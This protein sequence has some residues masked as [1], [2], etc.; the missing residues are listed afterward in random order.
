MDV[1]IIGTGNVG[2]ALARS[3]AKAGHKV[4]ITSTSPGE[5]N[6]IADEIGGTAAGSNREA[7]EAG[8]VVI[9]AVYFDSMAE[10]LDEI[11]DLLE[12]KVLVDVTNRMG[13]TPGAVV[14]GTSNAEKTQERVPQARVVKAF[15]TLFATRQ[16]DP[17]VD[18][19]P[20][21]A[22][23]A[24]DDEVAKKVVSELAG[25]MGMRPIDAG[26]LDSARI[27]E[28]MAVL[29]IWLNMQGGAWQNSWKL[30]EPSG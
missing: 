23:L 17:E 14:D 7:A 5:A 13:D 10:V 30:I 29:N 12:G 1:A 3:L 4:T 20:V 2:G 18:G 27:L 19:T 22:F 8:D 15:N 25:S 28:A 16:A 11:G 9:P 6:A 21:D 24:G 26:P